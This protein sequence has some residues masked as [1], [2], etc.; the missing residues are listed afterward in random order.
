MSR[1]DG[2]FSY[3]AVIQNK[4]MSKHKIVIY[5]VIYEGI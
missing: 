3:T 4:Q 2:F 1:L 5:N